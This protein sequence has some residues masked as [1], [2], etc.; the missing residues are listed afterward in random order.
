M[1]NSPARATYVNVNGYQGTPRPV[2]R[3]HPPI[4]IG[5]GGKR[6]LTYAGREADIVSINTVPFTAR[7]D[8]GLDTAGGGRAAVRIRP[9]RRGRP[10]R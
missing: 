2:Q 3:P 10:H 4:M 8:D 1:T 6:V 5:G 7:N 9:R